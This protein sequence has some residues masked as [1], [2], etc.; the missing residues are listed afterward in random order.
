MKKLA[1]V[2]V[3]ALMILTSNA[4]I[5]ITDADMPM[6]GRANIVAY[7]TST[8][9]NIGIASP[10]PQVWDFTSLT[11]MYSKLAI[12]S[13]TSPY[14]AYADSFPGSNIYTWGPSIFFTSFYGGAPVDV[15]NWGYMYWKTD[16]NGFHIVG[17]RGDCGPGYGY[18]NVHEAPQE[19]LMGTPATYNDQFADSARWV[20]KFNKNTTDYDTIY[21]SIRNKTISVDAYGTFS[22]TFDTGNPKDVIRVHEYVVEVDSIEAETIIM[23]VPYVVPL[24]QIHDTINNYYFWTN[25]L[26]YPLAIVHA[27]KN[28]DIK[29]VEF[30][31]DTVPCFTVTGNVFR[32]NGVT[33]V[34][35]GKAG[36]YIKDSYNHLFANLENVPIDENGNFQ[37]ADVVGPNYLVRAE[38]DAVDY[39]YLLPT[40]FG[41]TIY[42]ENAT[43]LF[44]DND[45][46]I[47]INCISDSLQSI[48]ITGPGSI[49]G[50][51]WADSTQVSISKN[52]SNT[53]ASR[54]VLV[55]LEQN[56]GGACRVK[57]TDDNGYY[58]FDDLATSTNYKLHV[59]IPGLIMDTTYYVSLSNKSTSLQF[60]DFYYDTTHIYT[61]FNVGITDHTLNPQ[62]DV[63]VYP[64]PFSSD[65]TISISNP[66]GEIRLVTLKVYDLIGQKVKEISE[67]TYDNIRFTSEGMIR[68]MYIYELQVDH[69]LISSGKI[70]VN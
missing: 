61:Y 28:N 56:P 53:V 55:T 30:I 66:T 3:S 47:S 49:S 68:G 16:V 4:Q 6:P 34:V 51:V 41:D 54:G 8:N 39:P 22:S 50:T 19:L 64:N 2:L 24:A 21:K 23:G 18:V 11:M 25:D 7:D 10:S 32:P 57:T 9:V 31:I 42:W 69:Q 67:E 26:N 43:T 65:A 20:L 46:N 59:D 63:T 1:F 44:V 62:Y 40:Y 70:V 17:F 60:L 13:P 29:F 35:N 12:Y 27:D 52:P 33:P 38:P 14:Q 5:T 37:F 36:L 15:N 45:T 48:F 58:E